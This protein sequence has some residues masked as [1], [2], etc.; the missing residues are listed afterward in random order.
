[1][2]T[3]T[4]EITGQSETDIDNAL[5]EV[6]R[7]IDSGMLSGHNSNDTGSFSFDSEGKY[8]SEAFSALDAQTQNDLTDWL[9]IVDPDVDDKNRLAELHAEGR[10]KAWDCPN[11]GD[12]VFQGE[13]ESWA[14]FQGVRQ[15]DYTSY[16]AVS[17]A[18]LAWCDHCRCWGQ[19][20]IAEAEDIVKDLF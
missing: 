8:E 12:R 14:D 13:P 3:F 11:C 15:V 1:M 5:A 2:K 7:L 19:S 10:F 18:T 4:I 16:P 20:K 6:S 9:N 17:R